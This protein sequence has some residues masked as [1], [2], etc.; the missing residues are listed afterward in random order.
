[1]LTSQSKG[2]GYWIWKPYLLSTALSEWK[3]VD[4]ILYADAGC[5]INSAGKSEDR[6]KEYLELAS[7]KS[8]RFAMSLTGYPELEWSKMDTM[9]AL[10]LSN[11]QRESDQVHATAMLFSSSRGNI[12]FCHEWSRWCSTEGYHLVDDSHSR[13]PNAQCFKDHRHDQSIFSALTK[14]HGA[15]IVPDETFWAPS[16]DP[17]GLDYPI[18]APR[19]RTRIG[20]LDNRSISKL[21]R[22]SEKAYSKLYRDFGYRMS[23]ARTDN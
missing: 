14:K 19:N 6:W 7:S 18:W 23:R 9:N 13:I 2:Y 15:A 3:D 10:G 16:W 11:E 12:E 22:F 8:G 20:T 5:E 4:F 21:I 17:D 1:M